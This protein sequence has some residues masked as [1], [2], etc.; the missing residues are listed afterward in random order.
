MSQGLEVGLRGMEGGRGLSTLE[1]Q[2]AGRQQAR[3]ASLGGKGAY[4][5]RAPSQA[6]ASLVY[7]SC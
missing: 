3:V 6:F 1:N 7:S 2:G 5:F 4:R